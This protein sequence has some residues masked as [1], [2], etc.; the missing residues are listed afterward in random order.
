[1]LSILV[2]CL[3]LFVAVTT[4]LPLSNAVVWWVRMWDFPRHHIAGLALLTASVAALI[5]I[6]FK[7][8]L[9]ALMLIC[10]VYQAVQIFPYTPLARK[11]V[12]L[13]T[14]PPAAPQVSMVAANVLMENTRYADLATLIQREDPDVVF[15][16]ETD[17]VWHDALR[18]TLERYPTVRT[19][20]RDDH[21]GLIFATRLNMRDFQLYFPANDNTAAVKAVLED[22]DGTAF[23]FVGLHPRPPVPGNDT[24][25]RDRQIKTAAKL[26][27]SSQRP[28]VCMGDFNDVAWSWTTRRF[29]RYGGF[30]EPRVGR[31]MVASFH[32]QHWLIRLPID[33]LYLT[34]D[35]GLVSFQRLEEFG[36]DHFPLIAT[37]TFSPDHATAQTSGEHHRAL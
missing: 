11:E 17:L 30:L 1:M 33:Q 3:G 27:A 13:I 29:K 20:L 10:A 6:P 31:G 7:P 9:I 24:D 25:A 18:E 35:V 14:P 37:V 16:M 4:A 19:H 36:S 22:A 32:A 34:P 8:V 12:D 2:W 26:T 15:L 28:T 5:A 23:N 21:Y